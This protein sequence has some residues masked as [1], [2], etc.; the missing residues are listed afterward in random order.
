MTS[1]QTP[2]EASQ[3]AASALRAVVKQAQTTLEDGESPDGYTR[4]HLE[5]MLAR[6]SRTLNA[7]IQMTVDR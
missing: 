1:M 6:A 3:L 4:A 2:A 7:G 5:D